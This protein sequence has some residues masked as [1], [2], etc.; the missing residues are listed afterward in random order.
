MLNDPIEN[1]NIENHII[2][3]EMGKSVW[4][5]RSQPYKVLILGYLNDQKYLGFKN[6]I[7]YDIETEKFPHKVKRRYNQFL[8]LHTRLVD[9]YPNLCIPSLPEK[10]VTGNFDDNFIQK[11][12]AKLELW[13]NR[14]SSHPVLGESEVFIHFL[15]CDD[16]KWKDGKR[17]AE[18]DELNGAQWMNAIDAPTEGIGS[19]SSTTEFIDKFS[20]D[21]N[22]LDTRIKN[23][24]SSL[25]KISLYR[26]SSFKREFYTL[27]KRFEDLANAL[28][29]ET[30]EWKNNNLLNYAFMTTSASYFEI[31]HLYAEQSNIDINPL[32]DRLGLYR[33]VL[34]KMPSITQYEKNSIQIYENFQAKPEKLDSSVKMTEVVSRKDLTTHV[35][36]AEINQ[37]NMDKIADMKQYMKSFLTDQIKFYTDITNSLKKSLE[38]FDNIV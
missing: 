2:I 19:F 3:N 14:L 17:K 35:M 36:Y 23:V 29:A 12:K 38:C 27:G 33:R 18:N 34:Q 26:R 21:S 7:T 8:W 11:R 10:V 9:R 28:S 20:K 31:S 30:M 22:R 32:L 37:F 15:I 25:E 6:F 13:L 4:K 1:I 24:S 5:G 16:D